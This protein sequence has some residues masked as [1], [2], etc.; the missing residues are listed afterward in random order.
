MTVA[1]ETVVGEITT[2]GPKDRPPFEEL[3]CSMFWERSSQATC[4]VPSGATNGSA[5][6]PKRC[7][8]PVGLTS[9]GALKVTPPS[10]ERLSVTP[11]LLGAGGATGVV[12]QATYTVSRNGLPALVSTVI[13]DLSL[14]FPRPP[15]RLKNVAVHV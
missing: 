7:P 8:P 15:D 12:S 13:I 2:G 6:I 9:T 1:I 4:S 14:N 11:V 3:A 10:I 5:P